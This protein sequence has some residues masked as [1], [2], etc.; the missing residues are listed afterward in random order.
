MVHPLKPNYNNPLHAIFDNNGRVAFKFE[1][2]DGS[3]SNHPNSEYQFERKEISHKDTHISKIQVWYYSDFICGFKFYST[4]DVV[5][6]AGHF[7]DEM[8]E[9]QLEAGERLVG[10]KSRLRGN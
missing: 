3:V 2:K 8:K 6:E 9:V 5:L 4:N 10:V 7:D 1:T